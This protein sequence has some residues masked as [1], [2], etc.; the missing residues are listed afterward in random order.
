MKIQSALL[1][2][3]AMLLT[4]AGCSSK[5]GKKTAP[6]VESS[7][8]G[9]AVMVCDASFE[10][11][12]QQEIDVFQFCYPYAFILPYYIDEHAAMD[13]LIHG[14]VRIGVVSRELTRE[15]AQLLRDKKR[16]PRTKRI[17]VDAIAVIVNPDN[18]VEKIS[19]GE[20]RDILSGKFTEWNQL[21]PSKLGKIQVIFDHNGS[22][23]VKYM[24][25]SLLRG[26]KFAPNVFSADSMRGVFNAVKERRNAI[27]LVGVS[28]ISSDLKTADL[29]TEELAKTLER[30]DTTAT[31]FV[32]DIKVL[33]VRRDSLADGYLPYQAYIFSGQYPLYRSI[34]MICTKSTGSTASGFFSFVTSFQ[35]QKLIQTT[36]VLPGT[37]YPRMVEVN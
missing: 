6:D 24:A 23:V 32:D 7:T 36:G 15:E 35:G 29:S 4:L 20:L 2:V 8:A 5:G 1:L 18:P 12:M 31:Q 27:G 13:S 19:M 25:D 16:V 14:N 3:A 33:K 26:E 30:D 37:V 21:E 10:N 9:T 17:A 34:Y 11:I 28:W 22:S